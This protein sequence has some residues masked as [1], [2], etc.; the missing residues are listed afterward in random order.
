MQAIIAQLCSEC[1]ATYCSTTAT[2]LQSNMRWSVNVSEIRSY[3]HIY[4]HKALNADSQLWVNTH[5]LK[6]IKYWS[7]K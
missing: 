7:S 2:T 3:V 1:Q 5:I 4:L 6:H